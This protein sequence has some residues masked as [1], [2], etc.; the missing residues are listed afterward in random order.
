M[1]DPSDRN[2]KLLARLE[3]ILDP[4]HTAVLTMELQNGVVGDEALLPAL[5]D[6]VKADGTVEAAATICKAARAAGARVVHCTAEQRADGVG[7]TEN[8]TIFAMNERNRRD[9]VMAIKSGSPGAA[10]VS[11]LGPEP[12]D[13]VVARIHGMTPF[14]STSLDQILRN[15]GITTVVAVGAS[16]NLGIIGLCLNALDLGYQV[17]VPRDA[18]SG[19]PADYA[20]AVIDNSVAVIATITTV[21]EVAAIWS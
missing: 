20:Q 15:M 11:E 3:S 7:A 9:G 5:V 19:V 10:I 6:Q 12:G 2:A 1:S 17:V 21:D 13:V 16:L 4:A 18:V 8:C 14:M